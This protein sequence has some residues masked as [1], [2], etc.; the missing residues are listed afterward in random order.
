MSSHIDLSLEG[1]ARRAARPATRRAQWR[2]GAAR[3][4][5]L[6]A[7][8]A[9]AGLGLTFAVQLGL[10]DRAVQ[11]PDVALAPV[12]NPAQI[13]GGPSRISGFDK[14]NLPYEIT[15]QKGVQD[16]SLDSLVHLQEVRSEFA[17]PSGATLNITSDGAEFE[18]RSKSLEL[19]G[20]VV[21]AEGQRFRARMDRASVNMDNQTLTSKSPVSVDIIGGTITADSLAIS[22]NGERILFKGGVKARF[23]TQKPTSGDGE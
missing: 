2:V 11:K 8:A 1:P 9:A 17:R 7:L 19:S 13:T 15:A 18:T 23:V 14:N 10:F 12:E 4:L 20:N 21:F 5:G 3:W 6:V 16:A 22:P